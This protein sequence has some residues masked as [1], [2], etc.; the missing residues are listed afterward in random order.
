MP[1]LL[2]DREVAR[3]GRASRGVE[4]GEEMLLGVAAG[5]D[6]RGLSRAAGLRNRVQRRE[7]R[8]DPMTKVDIDGVAA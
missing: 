8:A 3:N 1:F 2:R 6:Q 5:V 4:R 7:L